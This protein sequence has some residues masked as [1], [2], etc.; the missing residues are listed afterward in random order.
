MIRL[1]FTLIA[2]VHRSWS[3]WSLNRSHSDF[4]VTFRVYSTPFMRKW[5]WIHCVIASTIDWK[6]N[7]LKATIQLGVFFLYPVQLP[8]TKILLLLM[9][10]LP[11]KKTF[12]QMLIKNGKILVWSDGFWWVSCMLGRIQTPLLPHCYCMCI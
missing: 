12:Y 2:S 6:G 9:I 3:N 1:F 5:V 10:I 4:F 8:G 7:I 11:L